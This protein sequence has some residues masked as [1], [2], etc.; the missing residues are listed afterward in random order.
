MKRPIIKKMS[1]KLVLALIGIIAG[2]NIAAILLITLIL[3]EY[4]HVIGTERF[5]LYMGQVT[6]A[7]SIISLFVFALFVQKVFVKRINTL[8]KAVNQV[9]AGNYD[10]LLPYKDGDELEALASSFN[11]MIAELKANEF[12]SREFARNV[13]HEF[14]TPLSVMRGNAELISDETVDA[15]IRENAE[16]ILQESD[17][18]AELART[19]MELSKLDS[20]TILRQ[21]DFFTPAAQ[22]RTIL[23]A[24]QLLCENKKIELDLQLDDFEMYGNEQLLY[25]VWQNLIGN[26]IKFSDYGGQIK[27]S[28]LHNDKNVIFSVSDQGS[29]INE[30]DKAHIFELFFVGDR[31]RNAEGS[32]VGLALTRKIVEKSGGKI[33]FESKINQGTQ[34]TVYLP[35]RVS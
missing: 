5:Y 14:K 24:A 13:S 6:F 8:N 2:L 11:R 7:V 27:I 35:Y 12:L 25:R 18:L 20:T 15:N 29:G 30:V 33:T 22:I 28:L 19:L 21:E 3:R 4:I 31:S 9:A 17:R 10:V 34:F 32:G 23:Q 1:L 16:I 26:A